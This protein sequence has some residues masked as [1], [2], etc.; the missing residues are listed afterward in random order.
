MLEQLGCARLGN[1][2]ELGIEAQLEGV[3]FEDADAH[4]VDGADPRRIDLEGVGGE[5]LVLAQARTDLL[6]DLI[7]GGVGVG[8]D[9][10][11]VERIDIGSSI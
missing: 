8:D 7:G 11:V 3:G 2:G 5:L 1:E 4:A 6:A 9:E 10:D